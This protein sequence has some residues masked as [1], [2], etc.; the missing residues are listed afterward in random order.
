MLGFGH[1]RTRSTGRPACRDEAARSSTPPGG[2]PASAVWPAGRCATSRRPWACATPSLYVYFDSKNA[3]YDAMFADG[4]RV[5]L[6]AHATP[7][8]PT[9]TQGGSPPGR[10][11]ASSASALRG[12]RQSRIRPATSSSS[13]G[14]SPASSRPSPPTPSHG[15][16]LD[17]MVAA[18][19]RA[20][21]PGRRST[22]ISGRRWLSGL[23]DPA[24]EQRPGRRPLAPSRRPRGGHVRGDG[25]A[26][27]TL[28]RRV[29]PRT[30]VLCFLL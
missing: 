23:V 10:S 12:L 2:W 27:V 8:L 9:S 25:A 7:P 22:S 5:M 30:L 28:P 20:A 19:W 29:V 16:S 26:R 18:S 21:V 13:C 24:G 14:R 1:D 11:S 4:Y 6:R 15:R 3:L 17:R